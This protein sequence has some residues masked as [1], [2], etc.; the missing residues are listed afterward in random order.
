MKIVRLYDICWDTDEESSDE[1]GLPQEH[2]A[3]VEDD[4]DIE[5]HGADILSDKHGFCV[6]GCSFKVLDNPKLS[7][8]GFEMGDGGVIEYPDTDGTIRRRDVH[9]NLEEVR[10]PGS[11]NYQQWKTLFE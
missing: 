1:L 5:E 8:C 7:E 9:G 10:E 2:I 6:K 4:L 3:V 11:D